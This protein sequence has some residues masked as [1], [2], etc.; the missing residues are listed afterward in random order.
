MSLPK[1][2]LI[3]V[4]CATR[5]A[6]GWGFFSTSV[7]FD[8]LNYAYTESLEKAGASAMVIPCL[9]KKESLERILDSV[10]GVLFSGGADIAP[11]HYGEEMQYG[12]SNVDHLLDDMQLELARQTLRRGLPAFGIC[13][14]IQVLAVAAGGTLYQD[15]K[16]Q[17]PYSV[18]HRSAG[19]ISTLVHEID[20][21]KGSML[22]GILGS[23][24]IWINS[25]HHQAVKDIPPGFVVAAK[26]SDGLVEAMERKDAD[27]CLGV[28]WH[29]EGL[30]NQD[31]YAR[32][33]FRAF[34]EA[35]AKKVDKT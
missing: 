14:G 12:L 28:Q 33:L 35:C 21:S 17:L 5:V 20:V 7:R 3:G 8:G 30:Y 9:K 22:E 1:K 6:D 11:R 24:R 25:G 2:P 29:P 23:N 15:I 31:E 16:T 19:D 10:D 34:V 26:A 18:L 27:F 4:S 13:R 32:K